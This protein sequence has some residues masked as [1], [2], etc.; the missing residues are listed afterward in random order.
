MSGTVSLDGVD[1]PRLINAAVNATTPDDCNRAPLPDGLDDRIGRTLFAWCRNP[2]TAHRLEDDPVVAGVLETRLQFPV[3]DDK[4]DGAIVFIWNTLRL[5]EPGP[6]EDDFIELFYVTADEDEVAAHGLDGA[7]EEVDDSDPFAWWPASAILDPGDGRVWCHL[8][9]SAQRLVA[10]TSFAEEPTPVQVAPVT[11]FSVGV[12]ELVDHAVCAAAEK[13]RRSRVPGGRP[14][15]H[16]PSV[17]RIIASITPREK[18]YVATIAVQDFGVPQ[19][20]V[21]RLLNVRPDSLNRRLK[22]LERRRAS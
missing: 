1:W 19:A 11:T 8:F 17:G 9:D 4:P 7:G 2:I 3:H 13:Y 14:P 5:A 10:S 21:A 20:S 15:G 16:P 22:R 18:L 12:D 6:G